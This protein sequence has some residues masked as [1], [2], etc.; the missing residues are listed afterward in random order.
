M[1]MVDKLSEELGEK[2]GEV[3]INIKLRERSEREL[4]EIIIAGKEMQEVWARAEKEWEE[5]VLEE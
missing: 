5:R 2:H 3:A 4:E 1:K